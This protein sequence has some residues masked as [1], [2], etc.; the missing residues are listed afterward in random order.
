MNIGEAVKEIQKQYPSVSISRLRFLE[1]EGLIKPKRSNGGT[2]EFSSKDLERILKILNLQENLFYSLKA[3]K[4]NTEL[5]S[6]NSIKNIKIKE[7][8]KHDALKKA[9]LSLKNFNNLIEYNFEIEKE[10]FSQNDVDR[11]SSFA[12]FYN[13]GLSAKNFTLIKSL[14]DRGLGFF[15]IIKNNIDINENDFEIAVNNFSNI[16]RSYLLEE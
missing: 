4:N 8:S 7:Y 16:I 2:R 10:Q 6:K 15:E 5:L 13:L 1:K 12:Y 14:S 11:L 9:G 3:I